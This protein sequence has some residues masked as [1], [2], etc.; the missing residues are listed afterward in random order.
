MTGGV[1]NQHTLIHNLNDVCFGG[2]DLLFSCCCM[3]LLSK[4]TPDPDLLATR[5]KPRIFLDVA[6]ATDSFN[7]Y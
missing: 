6:N 1:C 2:P 3:S 4:Q 7:T 5:A